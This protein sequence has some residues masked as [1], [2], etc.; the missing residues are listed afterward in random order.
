MRFGENLRFLCTSILIHS[1]KALAH[2]V[3]VNE[4][5]HKYIRPDNQ[6]FPESVD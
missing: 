3:F 1:H 6:C 4:D 2:C 5:I